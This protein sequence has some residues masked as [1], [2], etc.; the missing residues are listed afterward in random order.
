MQRFNGHHVSRFVDFSAII[1]MQIR[2]RFSNILNNSVKAITVPPHRSVHECC[3]HT[4]KISNSK[5]VASRI[6]DSSYNLKRIFRKCLLILVVHRLSITIAIHLLLLFFHFFLFDPKSTYKHSCADKKKP[7]T[8]WKWIVK[9][10]KNKTHA[11]MV[12]ISSR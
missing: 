2:K 6:T 5:K 1:H 11:Q 8:Q 10:M 12:H 9:R 7:H 4:L 3:K